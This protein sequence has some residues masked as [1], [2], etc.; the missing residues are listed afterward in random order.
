MARHDAPGRGPETSEPG[1]FTLS[2]WES[3]GPAMGAGGAHDA[4]P[5]VAAGRPGY[6]PR[7]FDLSAILTAI[8]F[9][10]DNEAAWLALAAHYRENGPDDEAA[11]V[12]VFWRAMRGD[13]AERG[14]LEAVLLDVEANA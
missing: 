2:G 11:A 9:R 12:R 8:H 4:H 14:S 7:V 5:L 6:A 1:H 10:P 13:I 3:Q